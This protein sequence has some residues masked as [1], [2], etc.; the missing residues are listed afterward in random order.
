MDSFKRKG[1]Q[2]MQQNQ[3]TIHILLPCQNMVPTLSTIWPLTIRRFRCVMP[4]AYFF[5]FQTCT[6]QTQ[7]K[8]H[9]ASSGASK[10]F[11]QLTYL[12]TY[13]VV[14][15]KTKSSPL[16][17]NR[18]PGT[19]NRKTEVQNSPFKGWTEKLWLAFFF[20]KTWLNTWLSF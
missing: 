16:I 7:P 1:S 6:L 2:T 9:A 13:A 10:G 12:L 4:V 3:G 20:V 11:T 8:F 5:H 19:L 18:W 14:L 17:R 15:P